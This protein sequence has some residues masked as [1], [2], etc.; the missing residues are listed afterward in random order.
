MLPMLDITSPRHLQ[1]SVY[2][3][4]VF[5]PSYDPV[6]TDDDQDSDNGRTLAEVIKGQGKKTALQVM[7]FCPAIRG[8]QDPSLRSAW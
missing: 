4:P 5:H 6:N 3:R 8:D 7:I 2:Q 1:P